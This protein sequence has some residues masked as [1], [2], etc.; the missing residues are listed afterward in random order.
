MERNSFMNHATD[1]VELIAATLLAGKEKVS[2]EQIDD[3]VN[4]A[5]RINLRAKA[6][7]NT[8][9]LNVKQM[10]FNEKYDAT[11]NKGKQW[12]IVDID[13]IQIY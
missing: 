10:M 13:N 12:T 6:R 11:L 2:D 4:T 1:N 9:P 3:A 8:L 5:I 7:I